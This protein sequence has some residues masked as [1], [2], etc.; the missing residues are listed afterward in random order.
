LAPGRDLHGLDA[1]AGLDRVQ[2]C[3]ELPGAVADQEPEVRRAVTEVHQEV[4][5]LLDGPRPVRVRGDPEDV[6]IAEPTSITNRQNKRWS[7]TAQSTW[8]KS[9]ASMVV[10]RARRNCRHV[11]SRVPFRR[12][13]VLRRLPGRRQAAAAPSLPHHGPGLEIVGQEPEPLVRGEGAHRA[14]VAPVKGEHGIG[15]VPGRQSH[16]DR[17]G[18]V[19]VEACVLLLDQPG[20]A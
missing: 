4:T 1:G 16:I 15:P 3:G 2:G 13:G 6:H 14:E 20:R 19:Q 11:V 8:K 10:A 17:I 7:V 5:D 18:Q 9:A 12:W